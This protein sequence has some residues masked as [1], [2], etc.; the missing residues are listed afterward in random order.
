MVPRDVGD[1]MD[2]DHGFW[3]K[4]Q[5]QKVTRNQLARCVS[6]FKTRRNR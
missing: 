3:A 5:K 2:I 1:E 6:P 4:S